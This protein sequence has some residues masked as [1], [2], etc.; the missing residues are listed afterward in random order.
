MPRIRRGRH[1]ASSGPLLPNVARPCRV[2]DVVPLRIDRASA[3]G[4][5]FDQKTPV[6]MVQDITVGKTSG[7]RHETNRLEILM[8]CIC[9][10]KV[11]DFYQNFSFRRF[12][13]CSCVAFAFFPWGNFAEDLV[14]RI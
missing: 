8:C 3:A 2:A 9:L 10:L 13:D 14:S 5:K 7:T 12:F 4:V 6:R 1:A 11:G